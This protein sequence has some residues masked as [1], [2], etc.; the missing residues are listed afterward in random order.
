[1]HPLKLIAYSVAAL[2]TVGFFLAIYFTVAPNEQVVV[3]RFGEITRVVGPGL[4]FKVPFVH[5]TTTYK[6]D[7]LALSPS[8]PVNT[9]TE[10]NQEVDVVFTVFYTLDPTKIAMLHANFPD[11]RNR[12]FTIAVDRLKVEMGKI[13]VETL[14]RQRGELRDNVLAVIKRDAVRYG[15]NIA[16]F[17]L[18]NL[19]YDKDFRAA[20]QRAA[21]QKAEIETKE[22]E[23]LQS[24]KTAE[25]KV[26]EAQGN[27]D[28][29][30]AA[31]GGRADATLMQAKAEAEAIR[32]RGEAEALSIKAQAEA[33]RQNANLVELRKAEKW[34]GELPKSMLSNVMPFLNVDQDVVRK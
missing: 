2:F 30:R 25:R 20:V 19:E 5:G 22:Y 13:N 10:D 28:S 21:V 34:N 27:A 23:R 4:N 12:L 31:A 29:A 9:Y 18:D 11:F 1:M 7:E 33:L 32:L 24:I 6:M 26:I 14:A 15:V 3:T 8:K 16:G 17:Q